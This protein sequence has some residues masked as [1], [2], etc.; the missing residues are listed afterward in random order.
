[1]LISNIYHALFESHLTYGITIWGGVPK[2]QLDDI[3][4]IQKHCVRVLFGDLEEYLNKSCTCVRAR[5]YTGR[6]SQKLGKEY[7][8]KE[9]TK[10]LFNNNDLLA[11]RNLHT[12]HCCIEIF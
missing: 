4:K 11:V 6:G 5:P 9:H 2:V 8:C 1:M 7:Y 3:F 10:P 12:Y